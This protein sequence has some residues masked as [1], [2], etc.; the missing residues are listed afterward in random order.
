M[1]L[2]SSLCYRPGMDDTVTHSL[3]LRWCTN[4]MLA[5]L[6]KL[7]ALG[8]WETLIDLGQRFNK[9]TK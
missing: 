9:A 6:Q 8:S 4:F 7:F 1:P 5:T 3:D 2:Q